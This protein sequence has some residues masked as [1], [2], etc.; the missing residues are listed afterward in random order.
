MI[1]CCV[2]SLESPRQGDSNEYRQYAISSIEKKITLNDYK[3][4]ALRFFQGTPDRV[5][6]GRRGQAIRVRATEVL[7]YCTFEVLA[8]AWLKV[9]WFV[10]LAVLQ[11]EIICDFLFASTLPEQGR[12]FLYRQVFKESTRLIKEAEN[13]RTASPVNV[14]LSPSMAL[15]RIHLHFFTQYNIYCFIKFKSHSLFACVI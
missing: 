7:L 10:F 13:D 5:R 15:A 8:L 9:D 2:F 1:V 4:A 11:K 6:G 3:S 12:N 14:S